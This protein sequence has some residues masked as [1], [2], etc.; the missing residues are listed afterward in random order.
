[1]IEKALQRKRDWKWGED[2]VFC[3]FFIFMALYY[4]W[5]MFA[6]TPWY[7]ELYT[8]Y[9]F[10]S[11]G[12]VY[13]AIHWP[14]P[15]NHVGYSVLSACFGIF[16][17]PAV[18]LRGV[19]YLSSLMSLVLL[20]RIGKKI[21]GQ[22]IALVP[23][24]LYAG[25]NLT[26]QLAVQGRGYALVTCCYLTA[27]YELLHITVERREKKRDHVIFSISLVL[28]LYAIPS[29][30]YVV[31]PVCL[32]GGV[33]LLLQK[34]WKSLL[35]LVIVS[36][37]SALCTLFLYGLLWLAIGSN[38]LVKAKESSYF[39][40]GHVDVILHAPF[41]ALKTGIE[42]MLATPYIQS[43]ERNVFWGQFKDWLQTLFGTHY[44]F[45]SSIHNSGILYGILIVICV[46]L[47]LRNIVK[48]FC[49]RKKVYDR[50]KMSYAAF[51]DWYFLITIVMLPLF[52]I[53][54][55]KLPYFRV[56]SFAGAMIA[57]L[58]G[59]FWQQAGRMI[60]P[61]I[62]DEERKGKMQKYVNTAVT[63]FAGC[64]CLLSLTIGSGS[65]SL[66]DDYLADAY[67]Q[68]D[69]KDAGTIAVTDCDQ[70]YLLLYLYGIGKEQV[71]R[72]IEDADIVV[73]DKALLGMEYGYRDAPETWKF[74]LTKEELS[75][76]YLEREMK[77]IYENPHFIMFQKKG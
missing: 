55:S 61:L 20:Y 13:A 48:A 50:Q 23:V 31:I 15:N 11:K 67:R 38:L 27:V 71:T 7:D 45:A 52:L 4:G 3:M 2:S 37:I 58:A 43:V 49:D 8:Y 30:V 10:I 14:L 19:S 33:V 26:N 40:M 36:F 12:P 75:Q 77:L 32:I 22:G 60:V 53:V 39:G 46:V 1:M 56:F 28:A 6:L 35:R 41:T 62:R 65:Y 21:L 66:R 63:A 9:Y 74:Y 69:V 72:Q 54:Q 34:E 57:F 44:S 42:Y 5:R 73:L 29:S 17:N 59:W 68:I 70:E 16:G 24:Y 64:L 47:V 18:A 25:M 51:A 76:A